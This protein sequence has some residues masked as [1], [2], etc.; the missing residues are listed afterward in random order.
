MF[1]RVDWSTKPYENCPADSD[2]VGEFDDDDSPP[3]GRLARMAA[4][5]EAGRVEPPPRW[6][7]DRSDPEL[8][9]WTTPSG[10][11]YACNSI[12]ELLPLPD[13]EAPFRS[14]T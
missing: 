9:V 3:M 13:G 12:G 10:R 2:D 5:I 7:L 6:R 14:W 8:Q 4:A 11:R 1:D